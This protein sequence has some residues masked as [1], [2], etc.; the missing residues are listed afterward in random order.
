MIRQIWRDAKRLFCLFALCLFV[1]AVFHNSIVTPETRGIALLGFAT[2]ISV[3]LGYELT[4]R[5]L[6]LN[7]VLFI[8]MAVP[9]A[10]D[11]S[12][13]LWKYLFTPPQPRGPLIPAGEPSPPLACRDKPG[14]DDL[15]MAFGTNRVIGRGRGPFSPIQATDCSTIKLVPRDGGLIVEAFGF[16][17][18][19]D[20]AYGVRDNRLEKA[21]VSGLH[22]RRPDRS[23]FVLL[24]R[25]D[26][27]VVY[28]R[29][30]NRN[31]VRIRGRFLCGTNPQVVIHDA[32]T[33]IGGV[34]IGG[35][36]FGQRPTRGHVCASMNPGDPFGIHIRGD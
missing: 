34:R 6:P 11:G 19:N 18:N 32:Y 5:N 22:A 8:V 10:T 28:V 26:Q 14:P 21:F 30:L 25:F 23:S 1:L 29:Y 2:V 15:V 12:Y 3:L 35:V 33:L 9:P 31:A 36:K 27:E 13:M 16:D 17:W 7:M 4:A 24:D 20:V